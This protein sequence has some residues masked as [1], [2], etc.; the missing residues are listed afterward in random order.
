MPSEFRQPRQSVPAENPGAVRA[1]HLEQQVAGAK[2]DRESQQEKKGQAELPHRHV[3]D[4]K[5]QVELD[6]H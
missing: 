3:E 6:Q 1:P 5:D 2:T 4:G